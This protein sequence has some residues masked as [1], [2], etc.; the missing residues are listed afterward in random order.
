MILTFFIVGTKQSVSLINLSAFSS[1][2]SE[3]CTLHCKLWKWIK[4][5]WEGQDII[6]GK[7]NQDPL[8]YFLSEKMS[9]NWLVPVFWHCSKIIKSL[10]ISYFNAM[11]F[12][13][14][15]AKW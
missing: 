1:S 15:I 12:D 10:G 4:N 3:A 9:K 8:F 2:D 7:A 13:I 5:P 11:T 6:I 14:Y